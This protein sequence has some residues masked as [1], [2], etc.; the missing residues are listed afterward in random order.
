MIISI[1]Y[2]ETYTADP[3][4]WD[5]FCKLFTARGH[6]IMCVSAR[7]ETHMLPV[8][9]SLGKIIGE[10]NCYGVNKQP[11]KQTMLREY[12]I[13]IDIWIDDIPESIINGIA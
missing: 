2:D 8:K 6:V 3:E 7:D 9:E 12:G 1:D 11:K 13:L 5:M 4:G 10:S